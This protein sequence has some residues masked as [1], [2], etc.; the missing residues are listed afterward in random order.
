MAENTKIIILIYTISLALL[1]SGCKEDN[2][3]LG[4]ISK[5][6]PSKMME[7]E[8]TDYKSLQWKKKQ[9]IEVSTSQY[10]YC[11]TEADFLRKTDEVRNTQKQKQIADQ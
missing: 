11:F 10:R 6:D 8:M 9:I 5:N 2:I 3:P 7:Y 1:L 4:V